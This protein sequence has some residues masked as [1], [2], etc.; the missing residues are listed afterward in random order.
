MSADVA[1]GPPSPPSRASAACRGGGA[2]TSISAF[3]KPIRSSSS[4]GRGAL[5]P[6]AATPSAPGGRERPG[7]R[8]PADA[9][10]RERTAAGSDTTAPSSARR[11]RAPAPRPGTATSASTGSPSS[12][13]VTST[14]SA[15]GGPPPVRPRRRR[16]F[17]LTVALAVALAFG[18]V[19]ALG[20]D[21]DHAR[22]LRERVHIGLERRHLLGPLRHERVERQLRLDPRLQLG[23]DLRARPLT[24]ELDVLR[25]DAAITSRMLRDQIAKLDV[26]SGLPRSP[27]PAGTSRPALSDPSFSPPARDWLPA[28]SP[29]TCGLRLPSVTLRTATGC[30]HHPRPGVTRARRRA[31]RV[32]PAGPVRSRGPR[33][34]PR[35]PRS[36]KR[37]GMCWISPGTQ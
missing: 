6:P 25:L 20:H 37:F 29:V 21:L 27:A 28:L 4:P 14:A 26:R 9:S 15:T 30:A 32:L 2:A 10:R 17:A 13:G 35:P 22:L 33:G 12:T 19:V 8:S 1:P 34:P 3:A 36:S 31:G 7:P 16:A 18:V 11:P 5:L 24:R 23:D